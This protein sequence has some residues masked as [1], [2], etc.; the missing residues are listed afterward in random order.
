MHS[1]IRVHKTYIYTYTHTYL[2][3]YM[4]KI[5]YIRTYIRVNK[6]AYEC[7][8]SH[9]HKYMWVHAYIFIYTYIISYIHTYLHKYMHT[10]MHKSIYIHTTVMHVILAFN[11][12]EI[13]KSLYC[14]IQEEIVGSLPL[15]SAV[16][17]SLNPLVTWPEHYT[18]KNAWLVSSAV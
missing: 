9:I 16:L 3:T 1:Y 15:K 4:N 10:H 2:H 17:T 8:H 7:I 18:L 14:G 13:L 12:M 5:S 6:H 11:L